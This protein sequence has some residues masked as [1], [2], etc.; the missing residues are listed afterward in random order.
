M[1]YRSKLDV[2]YKQSSN[3]KP[4]KQTHRPL[5]IL[6]VIVLMVMGVVIAN[7]NTPDEDKVSSKTPTAV[8]INPAEIQPI[9]KDE[10]E[11]VALKLE[12]VTDQPDPVPSPNN[13]LAKIEAT[14]EIEHVMDE[15]E[16]S[17][18]Q[19]PETKIES[20]TIRRGDSL[21]SIFNKRGFN[22]ELHT[23]MQLGKQVKELKSIHPGQVIHIHTENGNLVA[24]DLETS[25]NRNL[26]I[27]RQDD[28]FIVDE[29]IRDF[30]IRTQVASST[31]TSSLF[32]AGQRA[33]MSDALIME[34]ANIFGWDIDFALD[35]RSGDHFSV[36]YEEKLLDGEKIKDGEIIAAEFINA[37]DR[38]RAIRYTDSKGRTDYYSQD[39][40][41][42][43]KPFLRTPVDFARVSSGF[44]LRRKH[45]V[46]NKIRAHK[47]VD[48]AAS[49]GTP[50]KA[51]G[52]GK[53]VHRGTK[54]GYGRTIIIKHGTQYS[55]LYAHMHKYARNT[56]TGK[57][58]KQG[59]IIGYVGS[60]GLA[61][62]PHL[63]YEFRINGVHRNPLT[64]KLPDAQPL[65]KDERIRFINSSTDIIA[66]LDSFSST[67]LAQ[68]DNNK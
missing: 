45:P 5:A 17:V 35:I 6:S 27:A 68:S 20:I 67:L 42:M 46:L 53:I 44:N 48:Y 58:V 13:T 55:T 63:H 1:H 19:I 10:F 43:R 21:S 39:G 64:V 15:I 65:P 12:A 14:E 57:R 60:S 18:K 26:K 9:E 51:S 22:R 25:I 28:K 32:L 49:T 62:G 34:L 31:I 30:E 16:E 52:D 40:R 8:L 29:V 59:Q 2:D 54:G 47:G 11:T 3:L 37:G 41:S 33:G 7:S 4:P 24:L 50:I 38:F 61:T 56:Q 66:Q 36:I 23:I